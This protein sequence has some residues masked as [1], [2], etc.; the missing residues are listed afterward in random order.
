[1]N[2]FCENCGNKLQSTEKFCIKCGTPIAVTEQNQQTPIEAENTQGTVEN[3]SETAN[4]TKGFI[5][6]F[7]SCN[8]NNS[9]DYIKAE[10]K[11]KCLVYTIFALIAAT[12]FLIPFYDEWYWYSGTWE[13]IMCSASTLSVVSKVLF[14]P[15]GIIAFI[16]YYIMS[17]R[18]KEYK[19]QNPTIQ[20]YNANI[21]KKA[22]LIVL[23]ACIV[24]IPLVNK[25]NNIAFENY[26]LTLNSNNYNTSDD[27]TSDTYSSTSN[28][29][30]TSSNYYI[31]DN[32]FIVEYITKINVGYD[33]KIKDTDMYNRY[34]VVGKA[35]K[36]YEHLA[37]RLVVYLAWIE[38]NHDVLGTRKTATVISEE[39]NLVSE[40]RNSEIW[41]EE[42]F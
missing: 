5:E 10:K 25:L 34:I 4:E 13:S 16:K 26:C 12:I 20:T 42:P 8:I 14:V 29:S 27:N 15:V 18:I 3:S 32:D 36:D 6:K 1:M 39:Y 2:N 37:D 40:M 41:N 19:I 7:F 21:N 11:R 31:K 22:M 24:C 38:K 35:G 23:V 30:S 9:D 17:K 33:F 28:V